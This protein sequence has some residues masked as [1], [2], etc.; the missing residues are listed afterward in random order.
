ME[1]LILRSFGPVTN[2][3]IELKRL[4]IFIG[5]Q[6]AGK[7]TVAKVLS[8]VRDVYLHHLIINKEPLK[9]IL[10]IFKIYG[11]HNYFKHDTYIEFESNWGII[12]K[13]DNG[14]FTITHTDWDED[15]IRVGIS[16][17]LNKAF[18]HI[19]TTLGYSSNTTPDQAFLKEHGHLLLSNMRASLYLS[20]ERGFAGCLSSSLASIMVS[21]IPLPDTLLEYLSYFEKAKKE[22]VNYKIP[23]LGLS[24][25]TE[26][27]KEYIAI[28]DEK[29]LF[30]HCSSGIQSIVPLLMIIDYCLQQNCFD[31]FAIEEPELNLFPTNQQELV[32]FL[33]SKMN[34]N[35]YKIDN[36]VLTTH[37]PYLLS[38]LNISMLAAKI[39]DLDTDLAEQVTE[40]L[41]QPYCISSTEVGAFSLGKNINSEYYC[42]NIIDGNTGLI[43]ANYLDAVSDLISSDFNKLYKLY[44]KA[45][46]NK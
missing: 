14:T 41:P 22:F 27:N 19:L 10:T 21:K 33:I 1:R 45:I 13:Y 40:I 17:Q 6:G 26:E 7:S 3:N 32:R 37:S 11:I 4:N 29:Y 5:E 34:N 44:I 24:F 25:F 23:F 43:K 36:L 46:R 42:E 31:S 30:R 8:C 9:N 16:A 2:L 35:D 12:V 39:K 15:A 38:V 18:E 20:A 28:K